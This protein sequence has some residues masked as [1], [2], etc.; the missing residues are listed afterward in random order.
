M[1]PLWRLAALLISALLCGCTYNTQPPSMYAAQQATWPKYYQAE[2]EAED[3]TRIRMT[4]YQ[5]RLKPGQTAP[6]L[7]HAHGFALHRMKRPLSLYGQVL[8]AGKVAKEAWNSGY[9]VISFDQR[10]F[11]NSEGDVGLIRPDKE[12]KDVS[13]VIDWAVRYLPLTYRGN[14]PVVGMIGESYGGG[15]QLA[16]TLV[17]KRIDALVPLTTW[18]NLDKALFPNDVAKS[19]WLTLLGVAGYA[20]SPLSMDSNVASGTLSEVFGKG[21]PWLRKLLRS[22]SLAEHCGGGSGPQADALLIQGMRDV[23]FP[24]NQALEARQCFKSAGRDVRLLAIEHGHMMPGSQ[25][26]WG[27]PVWNAQSEVTCGGQT[28]K[29]AAIIRDW[30][31]GKLRDDAAALA[32]VPEFCFTGDAAVDALAARGDVGLHW[33]QLPRVHVGSGLSGRLEYV[34]QPLD[35]LGNLFV[36]ARL[37]GSWQQPGNGWLRPARVPLFTPSTPTWIA[38]APQVELACSDTDRE[39]AVVFLRLAVWRPGA[40]SYRVLDDQVTPVRCRAGARL[41]AE[42]AAVRARLVPGEVLGL[43]VEG[44]SNQFRL[45]GSGLGVDASIEGRI[46]LPLVNSEAGILARQDAVASPGS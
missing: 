2:V 44:Y 37:P 16:A 4:V 22:N 30:L 40:G 17:D 13:R 21:D 46:G 43:L 45:S 32:R 8:L 20:V 18:S 28:L 41:V 7:I 14:D 29:T 31:D 35:R 33:A 1:P 6:L 9:W 24:F 36:P 15:V 25:W 5:P 26:Y 39:K 12:G 38:G 34:T 27:F 23:L 42:L 3:G 11:G 10:G 19:D